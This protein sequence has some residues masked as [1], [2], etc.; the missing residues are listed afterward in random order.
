[1]CIHAPGRGSTAA[2]RV[3]GLSAEGQSRQE[4]EEGRNVPKG[5]PSLRKGSWR[6]NV[7]QTDVEARSQVGTE[8]SLGKQVTS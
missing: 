1:M 4:G 3:G 8:W 2:D 5:R 6:T 7:R